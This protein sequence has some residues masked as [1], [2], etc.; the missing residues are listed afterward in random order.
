MFGYVADDSPLWLPNHSLSRQDYPKSYMPYIY[1]KTWQ[2]GTTEH[3][4][5]CL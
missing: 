4:S 5:E 3:M 1:R 2:K